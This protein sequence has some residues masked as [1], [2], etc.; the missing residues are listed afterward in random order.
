MNR[1]VFLVTTLAVAIVVLAA[2]FSCFYTIYPTDQVLLT[3]L[4]A[5]QGAITD[6]GL[7]FKI[8]FLQSAKFMP[9]Q[10]LNLEAPKAEAIALD[11]KRLVIDA[12]ARWRIVDPLKFFQSVPDANLD[13][14]GGLLAPILSS[15]VQGVL[16]KENFA[17]VLST[18]RAK[19]MLSIRDLMNSQV[20]DFGIVVVD[21]RI[22]R[23]DLPQANSEAIYQRMT[24]ERQRE[25]AEYRAEGDEI[26][27]TVKADAER[28]AV[29]LK[30]EASRK[31]EILKGEGDATKTKLLADAYG[32]DPNF[33]A[34]YRSMQ[35]YKDALPSDNTT[36]FLSP[37]SDFF[38]YF[39]SAP[40]GK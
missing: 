33:F 13:L 1:P 2:F 39:S 27:Q 22:R 34:F 15:S 12:F 8:P 5:P 21:V 16:G 7:H 26:S 24:K 4:G 18:K 37:K 10:L 32:Q 38:K 30:S 35:A 20:K 28:Q 31:A 25:A 19:L 29:V 9:R 17:A 14:A 11:K 23:A 40:E 3:K 6:P 36:V